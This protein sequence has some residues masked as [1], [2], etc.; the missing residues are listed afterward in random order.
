MQRENRY[1]VIK[2]ADAQRY[3]GSLNYR[4]LHTIADSV[5]R[6]RKTQGKEPLQCV[7]VESDW[8]EYEPVWAM[9]ETRMDGKADKPALKDWID[10]EAFTDIPSIDQSIRNLVQDP[11]ADNGTH[12]AQTIIEMY[13]AMELRDT[14]TKA[15]QSDHLK[16]AINLA[17]EARELAE[18]IRAEETLTPAPVV[19][20]EQLINIAN[21]IAGSVEGLLVEWQDWAS[22]LVSDLRRLAASKTEMVLPGG[23]EFNAWVHGDYN[24]EVTLSCPVN[25]GIARS[26]WKG[27]CTA[28][29]AAAHTRIKAVKDEK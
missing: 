5:E 6:G 20:D 15:P 17:E 27:C 8:P 18:R 24:R 23:A 26:A 13:R 25:L 14:A 2:E 7:V 11:T 1:I 16:R 22:E 3:L 10:F 9:I 21:H 29:L 12:M 28:M 4:V 19:L